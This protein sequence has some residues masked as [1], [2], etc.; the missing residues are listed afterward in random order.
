M[1]KSPIR[2]AF[3]AALA[4]ALLGCQKPEPPKITPHAARVVGVGPGS[5][6]LIVELDVQNPNPFPLVA[7]S[8]SGK[9][10]AGDGIELG[11]GHAEPNGSIPAKGSALVPSQMSVRLANLAAL[12]PMALSNKPVPYVFQ[13][14]ASIGGETLN[15]DVPFSV[16][17]ELTREQLLDA[18]LRGLGI[19]LQ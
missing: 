13:G 19:Q 11:T 2:F 4:L 5:L 6:S 18:G 1:S 7:R 15:L 8:V 10:T 14:T 17:G 12:A 16:K 3:G 9:L